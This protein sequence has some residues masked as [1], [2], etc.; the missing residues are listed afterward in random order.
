MYTKKE[1]ILKMVEEIRNF[2]NE[3]EEY[4]EDKEGLFGFCIRET[5]HYSYSETGNSILYMFKKYPEHAE[6]LEEML[7][8]FCGMNFEDIVDKMERVKDYYD[9]LQKGEKDV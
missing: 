3:D 1:K 9:S 4:E 5:D 8:A 7:G 6:I 2:N